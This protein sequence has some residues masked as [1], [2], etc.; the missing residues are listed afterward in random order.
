MGGMAVCMNGGHFALVVTR[1]AV[2]HSAVNKC[3]SDCIYVYMY[4]HTICS[5]SVNINLV[6]II[7]SESL[8]QL[9][10]VSSLVLNDL[11][12]P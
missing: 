9:G 6:S 11:K 8:Y 5:V 7:V 12:D 2:C 3:A 4:I 1:H 10:K